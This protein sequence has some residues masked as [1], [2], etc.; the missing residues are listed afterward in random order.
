MQQ[1]L[2]GIKQH[3][4]IFHCMLQIKLLTHRTNYFCRQ[5]HL[6]LWDC[7]SIRLTPG[8]NLNILCIPSPMLITS[9][10]PAN[11]RVCRRLAVKPRSW[12]ATQ[13]DAGATSIFVISFTRK[14]KTFLFNK[15]FH[16][17]FSSSKC[18]TRKDNR[19]DVWWAIWH[20]FLF[21]VWVTL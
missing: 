14:K 7:L 11:W 1:L 10:I 18:L 21:I 12:W 13:D 20:I 17:R 16:R 5:V 9:P 3:V 6:Y 2:S 19:V 4:S 15:A 8:C